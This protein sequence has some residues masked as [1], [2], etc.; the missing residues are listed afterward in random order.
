MLKLL[1]LAWQP[2]ANNQKE[3]LSIKDAALQDISRLRFLEE[4]RIAKNAIYSV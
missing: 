4:N 1:T 2:F 3:V